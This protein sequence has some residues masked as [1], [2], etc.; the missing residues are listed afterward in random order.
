MCF[1]CARLGVPGDL[2]ARV[3]RIPATI[4]ASESA[5]IARCTSRVDEC[6]L[7]GLRLE[8]REVKC[9]WTIGNSEALEYV[10][11]LLKSAC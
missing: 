3:E 9:C 4:R 8:R 2:P 11:E 1:A 10:T 7:G 5:K 6:V